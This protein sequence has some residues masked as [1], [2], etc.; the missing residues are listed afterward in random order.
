MYV[1][2][3]ERSADAVQPDDETERGNNHL[4]VVL[5]F[6]D[7]FQLKWGQNQDNQG[8]DT[9]AQFCLFIR[10]KALNGHIGRDHFTVN[11]LQ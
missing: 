4:Y 6:L 7:E 2:V 5:H 3:N 11:Q 10:D 8:D 9:Q 1:K